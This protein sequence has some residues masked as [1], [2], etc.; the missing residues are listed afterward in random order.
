M[1]GREINVPRKKTQKYLPGGQA[2][3]ADYRDAL[4]ALGIGYT[5]QAKDG[6]IGT[7]KRY[8]NM[9]QAGFYREGLSQDEALAGV[10]GL[11]EAQGF[12]LLGGITDIN[13]AIAG[14]FDHSK[15]QL[16]LKEFQEEVREGQKDIVRLADALTGAIQLGTGFSK[17]IDAQALSLK[18]LSEEFESTAKET[19]LFNNEIQALVTQVKNGSIGFEEAIIKLNEFRAA[20]G[21]APLELK[22]FALDTD[23]LRIDFVKMEIAA[24]ET[25]AKFLG[26]VDN[27]LSVNSEINRL[28]KELEQVNKELDKAPERVAK[29]LKRVNRD[30]GKVNKSLA[31]EP[32]RVAKAL[33]EVTEEITK[34][35]E[36]V[37]KDIERVGK[38]IENVTKE[39]KRTD[40]EIRS[41]ERGDASTQFKAASDLRL[42]QFRQQI[43][44]LGPAERIAARL[45]EVTRGLIAE[46]QQILRLNDINANI[47]GL[48]RGPFGQGSRNPY[49]E[50]G[51]REES[52][53][54]RKQGP[55]KD[56]PYDP[57]KAAGWKFDKEGRARFVESGADFVWYHDPKSEKPD[58]YF[59]HG[60]EVDEETAQ[61]LASRPPAAGAFTPKSTQ[62]LVDKFT[63]EVLGELSLEDLQTLQGKVLELQ[64]TIIQDFQDRLE[65]GLTEIAEGLEEK[66]KKLQETTEEQLETLNKQYNVSQAMGQLGDQLKNTLNQMTASPASPLSQSL[67]FDFTG[68]QI[69]GIRTQLE[70][71]SGEDRVKLLNELSQ[72]LLSRQSQT[73]FQRGS[74]RYEDVW[75]EIYTELE[76][77]RDEAL[78]EGEKAKNIQEEIKELNKQANLEMEKLRKQAEFEGEKLRKQ[79]ANE[80]M[81]HLSALEKLQKGIHDS[82]TK[83]TIEEL[84]DRKKELEDRKVELEDQK[85]ILEEQLAELKAGTSALHE[86]KTQLE[87][88]QRELQAGTSVLHEQKEQLEEQKKLLEEQK[89]ALED[90]TS[91]LHEQKKL[92][93]DQRDALFTLRD[94]LIDSAAD[95]LNVT[96]DEVVAILK[97]IAEGRGLPTPDFKPTPT[98]PTAADERALPKAGPK[99][100]GVT[101]GYAWVRGRNAQGEYVWRETP[102]EGIETHYPD[103]DFSA[104]LDKAGEKP[105][106]SPRRGHQWVLAIGSEGE[107]YQWIQVPTSDVEG[108]NLYGS[109]SEDGPGDKKPP[110]G[111]Y[112]AESGIY[113]KSA[114]LAAGGPAVENLPETFGWHEFWKHFAAQY[115]GKSSK[116][117]DQMHDAW[118]RL[119]PKNYD[120]RD[121]APFPQPG[122]DRPDVEAATGFHGVVDKPTLFMVGEGNHPEEVH[123]EPIRSRRSMYGTPIEVSLHNTNDVQINVPPGVDI[124]EKKL[125]EEMDNIAVS[126]QMREVRHGRIRQEFIR[127]ARQ[128]QKQVGV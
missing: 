105:T 79:L 10:M 103:V 122:A 61:K 8:A 24:D 52:D 7:V 60:Q 67:R 25:A 69:R 2:G 5:L 93:E 47:P 118:L 106:R 13:K 76:Q 66:A 3:F 21:K 20:A 27:I 14:G 23:K 128:A 35:I 114:Y 101:P 90:G 78:A 46:I 4:E 77:I 96:K 71:A 89:K 74:D 75:N 95:L 28:G 31:K 91:A 33:K 82:I 9:T 17:S 12:T 29:E 83:A 94:R 116:Y 65:I 64:Q 102:I 124:D 107:G 92:L 32:E 63:P 108:I 39:I 51:L 54:L 26:M 88:L 85:K 84:E 30:L 120:K 72:A 98:G 37:G 40:A 15:N 6:G 57:A 127:L 112:G 55:A 22:D 36:R 119:D 41:L 99:P 97:V 86:Q 19:G 115:T 45:E 56:L 109:P 43:D 62:G 11:A 100:E 126:A 70:S 38:E 110:G 1:L 121:F 34:S 81:V 113:Q 68:R 73:P 58:R 87:E 111:K 123:I 16:S 117:W 44:P 18:I 49:W 53:R 80:M 48:E 104:S 42:A 125:A 59:L 50:S